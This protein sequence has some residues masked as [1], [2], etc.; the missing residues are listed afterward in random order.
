MKNEPGLIAL[1]RVLTFAALFTV[2]VAPCADGQRRP[3]G[4]GRPAPVQVTPF[5]GKYCYSIGP[6]GWAVIAENAQR[7]AFGA[8]FVSADGAAYA[9]FGIFGGGPPTSIQGQETPDRAVAVHLSNF[10]RTPTRFGNRVQIA[11]NVYMLEYRS[12][13]NRGVAFW[14]VM[15][16]GAGGFMITMRTAGTGAAPGLF[17]K[18]GA[19]AMAVARYL[20]CQVPNVPAAPDPPGLTGTSRRSAGGGANEPDTLYNQWLDKETYHDKYGK[21]YWVSPSQDITDGP[22]GRGYYVDHGNETEFLQPGA[23]R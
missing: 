18:R 15:S 6:A 3:A 9:G 1:R 2:C 20:H 4:N 8:D 13:T 17:E 12:A 5:R 22:K 19:E 7:V 16:N 23:A 14:N 21:D 10:G 11:P